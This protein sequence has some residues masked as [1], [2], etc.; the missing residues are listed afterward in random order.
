MYTRN[1][2]V[3]TFTPTGILR[4]QDIQDHSNA[5]GLF[6]TKSFNDKYMLITVPYTFE[7][8]MTLSEN[9]PYTL[10]Q[11]IETTGITPTVY[12]TSSMT[13]ENNEINDIESNYYA[14]YINMTAIPT[15]TTEQSFGIN[16]IIDNVD[17]PSDIV[18]NN[19]HGSNVN[20]TTTKSLKYQKIYYSTDTINNELKFYFPDTAQMTSVNN[21]LLTLMIRP[22]LTQPF[23]VVYK[24]Y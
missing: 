1:S 2:Q 3:I 8:A 5:I 16:T 11:L 23:N 19:V 13:F 18:N 6:G 4:T 7:N 17:Y 15:S 14:V 10:K 22:M 20:I 12:N 21:N 9:S 24:D